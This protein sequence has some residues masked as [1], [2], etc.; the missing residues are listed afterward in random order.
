MYREHARRP[1]LKVLF[2]VFATA[3]VAA[4]ETAPA[5]LP[6]FDVASVKPN[7]TDIPSSSRFPLGPG[8]AYERGT[9]FTAINQPLIT[10]IRFAFGRSQGEMLRVPAWV[11]DERFDVPP[12]NRPRT[13]CG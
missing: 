12:A 6:R 9:V 2:V 1:M 10:Y 5:A 7:T 4:Q 8:D 3:L 11:N 13:T